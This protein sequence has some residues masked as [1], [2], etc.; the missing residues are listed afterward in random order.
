MSTQATHDLAI[1]HGE[2]TDQQGLTK[3]RW[4][5]VGTLLRH[6]DG[7]LSIK[8][9]CLPVG[10]PGWEGWINAFPRTPPHAQPRQP[11]PARGYQAPPMN[12]QPPGGNPY[13][14]FDDEIPFD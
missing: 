5:R 9:D 6:D 10:I 11:A 8:L 12:G 7:G 4:M 13:Q 14:E 3:A 1:K 2:Y